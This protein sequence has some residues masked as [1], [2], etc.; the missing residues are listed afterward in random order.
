LLK[1]LIPTGSIQT[2]LAMARK[3]DKALVETHSVADIIPPEV[4]M[5]DL[6]EDGVVIDQDTFTVK[7]TAAGKQPITSMRLLV[8]GRPFQGASGVKKF[9]KAEA[10]AEASWEV[11]LLPGTHT[12]AV[13]ADSGVSRGMSRVATLTRKGDPPKP[14]LYVLTMGVS[15]YPG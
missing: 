7:A 15:D 3:F 12:F 10:N 13:I 14:N 2:A 5:P 1:Y 4:T 8:D 9:A 6:S 11:P